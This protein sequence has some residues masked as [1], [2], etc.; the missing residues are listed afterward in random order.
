MTPSA[1][2][3]TTLRELTERLHAGHHALVVR[4]AGGRTLA[5]DG[6]GVSD[7]LRLH[8]MEP[9]TLRGAW[10][11]DKVVGKAAAALMALGHI[12][13]LHADVISRGGLGLL[14]EPLP[15]A[16]GNTQH[17]HVSYTTLTDHITNRAGTGWCPL[18]RACHDAETP[19][20]CLRRIKAK[21]QDMNHT[22][23]QTPTLT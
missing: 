10:V 19:E 18:E 4:T 15:Q 21:L 12:A 22:Q 5:F 23:E 1:E 6:R 3:P 20:E 8:T 16:D 9:E 2:I 7:L 13:A 14:I 11:A 17:A